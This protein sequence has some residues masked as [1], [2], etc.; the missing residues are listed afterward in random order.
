MS[1]CRLPYYI[2]S[3]INGTVC[4]DIFGDIP[5]DVVN[6][7]L[8]KI[9]TYRK[10]EFDKRIKDGKIELEKWEESKNKPQSFED[11][12]EE[13]TE[14]YCT[15]RESIEESLKE[16]KLMREGKIP[17]KTW[18]ECRE[19]KNCMSNLQLYNKL[20]DYIIE[21]KD[22]VQNGDVEQWLYDKLLT[23]MDEYMEEI[24]N[25]SPFKAIQNISSKYFKTIEDEE[26]AQERLSKATNY[27][28]NK[29]SRMTEEE[30]NKFIN[31]NIE[32]VVELET[33]T[34]CDTFEEQWFGDA[35][36]YVKKINNGLISPQESLNSLI[37]A[38]ICNNKGELTEPYKINNEELDTYEKMINV[39]EK[40]KDALGASDEEI[41]IMLNQVREKN[42][43]NK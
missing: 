40:F 17:K 2:Y 43:Y 14:R 24:N 10:E 42:L 1:Y 20:K 28:I 29:N 3:N 18:R 9:Y 39:G 33:N 22:N 27:K 4:F 11:M 26:L 35:E 23:K 36:E 30:Y 25:E 41:Y 15:V 38:G 7:F 31:D 8:Y 13:P 6:I 19:E 21:Q 16:V 32:D 34:E 5:D 37:K 12:Y